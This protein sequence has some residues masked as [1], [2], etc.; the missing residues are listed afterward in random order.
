MRILLLNPTPPLK[1]KTK[2]VVNAM[3]CFSLLYLSPYLKEEKNKV[4]YLEGYFYDIPDILKYIGNKK[5]EVVCI[6]IL[7]PHWDRVKL[8]VAQIKKFYP[9]IF[10]VVGGWHVKLLQENC[11]KE[12]KEIDVGVYVDGE[13]II[14]RVIEA[15]KEKRKLDKIKGIIFRKG[16]KVIK[17]LPPPPIKNLDLIHFP[18][19]SLINWKLYI[20][21]PLHHKKFPSTAIFGSRGCPYNCIFCH[22]EKNVRMRSAKNIVDEIEECVKKYNLKDFVFYDDIF[23]LNQKR[24]EEVCD[25]IIKR[26]LKITWRANGRAD[27][28]N[29]R[30]LRKM[31][32]AGCWLILYG[33]ESGVQKNL[34]ILQKNLTLSQIKEAIKLTKKYG[35]KTLGTFIF[36]IPTETLR[37]GLET[38]KFAC[39]LDLDY[40]NFFFLT[41]YFGTKLYEMVDRYGKIIKNAKFDLTS[42]SFIPNTMTEKQLKLL[43]NFAFK[44]FY[45]RLRTIKIILEWLISGD[46]RNIFRL[47]PIFIKRVYGLWEN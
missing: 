21:S 12:C 37:E 26:K 19:R 43:C 25:E 47:I 9:S 2:I 44:K 15:L 42:I 35:I 10:I 6:T 7:T 41:P 40:A 18:D 5:I 24:A 14:K 45:F 32:K 29:K 8:I 4:F 17:N 11:L 34:D 28:V 36:G 1:S 38:I 39:T 3:P 46:W 16:N 22:T 23:T 31:R 30:L 33:I 13:F 20:P 27:I